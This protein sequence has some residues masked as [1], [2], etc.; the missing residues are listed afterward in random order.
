MRHTRTVRKFFS[1]VNDLLGYTTRQA[2][3]LP[4]FFDFYRQGINTPDRFIECSRN[5]TKARGLVGRYMQ[6]GTKANLY[7]V[8]PKA[9]L[10]AQV[11][12]LK[13][14]HQTTKPLPSKIS[15]PHPTLYQVR[16]AR[17]ILFWVDVDVLH[18]LFLCAVSRD[19]HQYP[20]RDTL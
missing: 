6:R 8:H 13:K 10:Y 2:W 1:I 3:V 15:L 12:K 20:G 11:A 17:G 5:R 7:W 4:S 16:K 14:S 9:P 19:L 18:E